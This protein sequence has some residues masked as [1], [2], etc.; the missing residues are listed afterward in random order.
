MELARV[1]VEKKKKSKKVESAKVK[2]DDPIRLAM[3]PMR[4]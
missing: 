4:R 3:G 1:G 2:V